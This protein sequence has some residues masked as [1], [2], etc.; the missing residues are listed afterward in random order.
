MKIEANI[1]N[2]PYKK[3]QIFRVFDT[4]GTRRKYHSKMGIRQQM[5]KASLGV[6]FGADMVEFPR[7]SFCKT[8]STIICR[9]GMFDRFF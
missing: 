6:Q 5:P 2:I 8:K 7:A 1:S 3:S 9:M 4:F